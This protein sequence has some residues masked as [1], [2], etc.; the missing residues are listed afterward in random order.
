[1]KIYWALP[2]SSSL[3]YLISILCSQTLWEDWLQSV[4]KMTLDLATDPPLPVKTKPFIYSHFLC[5]VII[6]IFAGAIKTSFNKEFPGVFFYLN[7]FQMSS[8]IRLPSIS[9][10][11]VC[12]FSFLALMLV[13]L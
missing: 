5:G 1:M 11:V 10:T 2:D 3:N 12:P 8:D 7:S 13:N 6:L 9:H 4:H